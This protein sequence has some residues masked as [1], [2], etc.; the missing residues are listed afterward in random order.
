MFLASRAEWQERPGHGKYGDVWL[1]VEIHR[2]KLPVDPDLWLQNDLQPGTWGDLVVT[3]KT[4]IA[5][6]DFLEVNKNEVEL[7][8]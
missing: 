4:I 3:R 5:E 7:N 8:Y 6:R 2:Y 1:A